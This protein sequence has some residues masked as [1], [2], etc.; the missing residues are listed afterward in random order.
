MLLNKE[1]LSHLFED[2]QKGKR[3]PV[4]L[5]F[6]DEYLISQA[7]S[8]L[9]NLL[10]TDKQSPS[11]LVTVDGD[12]EQTVETINELNTFSL[13]EPDKIVWVKN[14][15][16]FY[17]QT[18]AKELLKQAKKADTE[19]DRIEAARCFGRMM[20]ALG[21]T[22]DDIRAGRLHDLAE[23]QWQSTLGVRKS[24]DEIQW[25]EEL[26]RFLADSGM[27]AVAA[28]DTKALEEA[29]SAGFAGRNTLILT[30]LAVD[31]RSRLFG[32]IQKVGVV[33]D[34]SLEGDSTRKSRQLREEQVLKH[35]NERL[36]KEKKKIDVPARSL[37]LDRTG[38][39]LRIINQELDKLITFV[40]DRGAIER[41][42]VEEVV[43][44][45]KEEAIYEIMNAVGEKNAARCLSLFRRLVD[46]EIHVMAIQSLLVRKVR[47]LLWA[48]GFD[49]K[50]NYSSRTAR[51]ELTFSFFQQNLYK[52]FDDIDRKVLGAMAPW[53]I[54]KLL[55]DAVRFSV[56][57]LALS[58]EWL[59]EA[60]IKLKSGILAPEQLLE[61]ILV[62]M[63]L[64][65]EITAGTRV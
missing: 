38:Y 45:S 47:Q 20:G 11:A 14:S 32:Q 54:Y 6:G 23:K 56:N 61:T 3:F 12:R 49:Y 58:M 41:R 2:L 29:L 48:K 1:Q 7:A 62:Q 33:V 18:T 60:D 30:C 26:V 37:F 52:K 50:H 43:G 63:C 31:K 59:L 19:G 55:Q 57:E 5:L 10:V 64:G 42:D 15:R 51:P 8:E 4:F 35:L 46:Q 65:K 17:S 36:K 27:G 40:G 28:H 9:V 21:W 39:D 44:L 53:A 24:E 13:F 25:M 22:L 16:I 34:L